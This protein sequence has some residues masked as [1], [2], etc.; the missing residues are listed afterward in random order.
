T[1]PGTGTSAPSTTQLTQNSTYIVVSGDTLSGIASRNGTTV[2]AIRQANNLT[3][4]FLRVG[5]VLT[6]PSSSDSVSTNNNQTENVQQEEL[7]WLAKIIH[8]EARGETLLGQIA[9]G[10]VI[11]NRVE[12]NLF[13]NTVQEVIFQNTNGLFQFTP[14]SNGTLNSATP[15]ETNFDAARRALQGEDPTNGALYFYNPSKT[16]DQW[17][18]SRTVSTTI[19][20]HVFAY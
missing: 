1:I 7:L 20:N 4:D 19:E 2:N 11:M 13:P 14:A 6:I 17:V 15:N 8:S 3:S 12:S 16:N 18:R 5:Q 10:A 9:V